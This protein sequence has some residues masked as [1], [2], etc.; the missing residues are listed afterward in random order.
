M[1]DKEY[2]GKRILTPVQALRCIIRE[3]DNNDDDVCVT[4]CRL[5]NMQSATR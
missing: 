3:D 2:A 1:D 4:R 5:Q